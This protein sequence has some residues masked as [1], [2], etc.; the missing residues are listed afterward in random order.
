MMTAE[1][2][3]QD[4]PLMQVPRP[5]SH[6]APAVADLTLLQVVVR[7]VRDGMRPPIPE[8]LAATP[9]AALMREC[10]NEEPASRP[11]FDDICARLESLL[12][13]LEEKECVT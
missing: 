1:E 5:P 11:S 3:Y 13:E 8:L 10:W 7:V 9:Y 6:P 4:M 12:T 2:P